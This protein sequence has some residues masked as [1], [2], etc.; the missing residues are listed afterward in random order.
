MLH[1]GVFQNLEATSKSLEIRRPCLAAAKAGRR[2]GPP[3]VWSFASVAVAETA[4]CRFPPLLPLLAVADAAVAVAAA[5]PAAV[6]WPPNRFFGFRDCRLPPSKPPTLRCSFL[7]LLAVADAAVAVAAAVPAAVLWPPNRFFG[8]RD[9]RLPSSKPPTLRCSFLSLL[10]VASAAVAVA[11]VLPAAMAAQS[12]FGFRDASLKSFDPPLQHAAVAMAETAACRFPPLLPLLA[13]APAAVAVAAAVPAAMLWPP[14]LFFG[15]RDCRLPP[16]K[17][18]R[19][20]AAASFHC[21]LWRLLLWP[22][23]LCSLLWPHCC[24]AVAAQSFL[25]VPRLPPAPFKTPDPPLQLPFTAGC[26]RCCCGRGRCGPCCSAVAA[27]SFL[28]VPRL[29]PA[30]SF[31]CWLWLLLLWPWPRLP[32]AAS[33]HCCH[34]WLWPMLLWPWPLR[35]LLQCCG[36]PI[37]S[38]S[39]ETAAC[40]LQNLRPSAAASFHCWLWPM[41]LWPWPLRSLLLWP[42]PLQS[43]LQCCGRPIF[44]SG[45]ETAACPLQNLR[46]SAAASFH[47]WLWPSDPPLQLPSTAAL[48]AVAVAAAV[49]CYGRTGAVLWPP[50]LFFGFRDCRLPPSKPPTLR[51]SFL[52]L[53]AVALAA[54]AVAAVLPAAMAAQSFFGFRDGFP[55]ILRPSAAAS[56]HCWLW[57]LLLWPWPRLPPAPLKTSDPPLQLPSTASCVFWCCGSI[58]GFR[59]C[60]LPLSKHCC[61]CWPLLLWPWPLRSL[62]QCCGRPIVSSGSETAACPL[63]NLRPSAAASFHCWLWPLLLWPWPLRSLLQCCGRPIV[64]SGSETAACPLQNLR[65][66]AAASFHCWLWRLLLWPWP[67]CSLLLWPHSLSL[68]SETASLKSFDPPLQLLSTA[69]CGSCCCGHGRDCRLP[70]PSTAATA[71]CGPCCC[72]RGRCSPC[73]SAVAAQSFLRVPRLPPAPFKTSDPS[74]HCWL[75]PSDPPLQLPSTAALAAVAVAAAVPC[76]GRTGAVLWPPNLFFGF[77]DC[78]LPPSKPPTLRCSFLPLLAVALAAVAVAAVLPAAMAAQSF[79]G[80]RDGFPQILRSSA[81]F[82][83]GSCCCGHGRD[84]R[85]PP[86]KPP[87]LR[88]SFL[89]LLAV[90]FGAVALSSGSETAISLFQNTAATAGPCCCGRGR[91]GPCC[92]A[93]AAQSFLRVPRL[94]PA[95]FKT[96]DPPLQLP[97]TAGCGPCC[98]G[99]GRCGPCCSAVAAQSFLQ[100]P[101]LPPAPFKTSDPPLQLPFTAGCGVC[102]C[103]RGRCAPCCYG[104]TVFLWVP[105]RLP[106]NPSTLR[107]KFFP[108]LAVAPAAVAMAETAAC[109]FPPLLPL[110]AVAPAAVAVAA[111]VPAAVLWPPNLFFGFRDCRL[112]PSKPPTLPSTAGCGPPT[113]RC[114]FPPLLP[115]LLWPWPLRSLLECCGRPIV[116]SGSETAACPLQNLRPS[117]AAS[118]HCWLWP[119]LLW[120]WPLRSLLQCCGRPIVSSGSETAACPLQNLRPS[121]AASFHCWLWRLLLWPWP[122][123]SLLLWPHS[124][125][126]GSETASLKSFD[127]PLQ[128]LSTAGCGSCCCGHGRDCR[129]P[130]SKPPTLRCSFLPLLAVSFGAVALSLGSETAIS[131][132]RLFD[133]LLVCVCA[134]IFILWQ[135]A[136]VQRTCLGHTRLKTPDC[137]VCSFLILAVYSNIPRLGNPTISFKLVCLQ[138]TPR[139]LNPKLSV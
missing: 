27:Q 95:P 124:L 87:T 82:H 24:S 110:L 69:G 137:Q 75:W 54:V 125:S 65:P 6:L 84:C 89:P 7:S 57:L 35:S 67:L 39:S 5:V 97:F 92:S 113:L 99:R 94:P 100:V 28:R 52:P 93:V 11:A 42:W 76:Y 58:F 23:P 132:V 12:F 16:S 107:C 66:S 15:F 131:L 8:F 123:C 126:L 30:A 61:H 114:S 56:F 127:P 91:C 130:P 19:P 139:Q 29:P 117:A 78:R 81:A 14:N 138:W 111:A 33:L 105:R 90:S 22:W 83:C 31:H 64:S 119:L 108:L 85:L 128:L 49:P 20:S 1:E 109:R 40:P 72:G 21:W 4:A 106:S 71:G 96:F 37:V 60:H 36:R 116:S 50:N 34:C 70:L 133:Q 45:S 41:L 10:A 73:C 103:G 79:F 32:P 48:A 18:L 46:P 129:L 112:P 98:C 102:C 88:C 43:L 51:C 26:G 47:C 55:Q 62:L 17:P 63:Q 59:D 122:L 3:W 120:P 77:R 2:L 38:S 136:S 80:F 44:S 68:G 115:L 134:W 135:K 9:C 118:F 13:V 25:R 86:S 74:F 121:A 101:R 53:L 104:R